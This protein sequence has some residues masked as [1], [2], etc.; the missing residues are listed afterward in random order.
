MIKRKLYLFQIFILILIFSSCTY[1]YSE[2]PFND[3]ELTP[4]GETDFGKDFLLVSEKINATTESALGGSGTS[5]GLTKDDLIYVV[6]DEFLIE[7]S[8]DET[9]DGKVSLSYLLR[10]DTHIFSCSAIYEPTEFQSLDNV[11]TKET[12]DGDLVISGDVEAL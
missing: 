12:E 4:L 1:I 11:Q 5:E 3:S 7:Q 10:N 6:N 8:L 2:A 9:L